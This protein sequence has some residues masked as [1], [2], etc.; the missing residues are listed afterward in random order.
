[1]QEKRNNDPVYTWLTR[2]ATEMFGLLAALVNIQSGTGNK[3]GVDHVCRAIQ[4][5]METMGFFCQTIAQ[6]DHG[7][8]LVARHPGTDPEKKPVLITGHMD[9]VFPA[10]TDFTSYSE[11]DTRC[12]GPG[13]ADMKGGLVMGLFGIKA[14]IE[15]QCPDMPPIVFVFNA[16]EEIGSPSSRQ[17]I[18]DLA[19]ETSMGFVLEAGGLEGEIV[20]ARKGN[21]S[22]Q[23]KVTGEAGHAAF[24]G[25]DKASAILELAHKIIAIETLHRPDQGISAN[26]GRVTG[27]IGPNTVPAHARAAVDFRF[28][29]DADKTRLTHALDQIMAAS[30]IPGTRTTMTWIS[31]RPAMPETPVSMDLFTQ[32]QSLGRQVGISVIPERRQGVSDANIIFQAGIPVIDGLGPIGGNDH[33]PK[34]YI[35]KQSLMDRARLF[36]HILTRCQPPTR[37]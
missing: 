35:V 25:P 22:V 36:A 23:I 8:H 32:I 11:D 14:L 3:P 37:T 29:T 27:G 28:T 4:L 31:Q 10:D 20:V 1:M 6:T 19:R 17:L 18:L 16:D 33:S 2:H 5:E 15:T 7:D 9:T 24:A 21:L 34:E 30:V 12:Y 26:V 13:T